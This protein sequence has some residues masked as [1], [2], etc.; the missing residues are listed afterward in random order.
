MAVNVLF[1]LRKNNVPVESELIQFSNPLDI[2][3][4]TREQT[5]YEFWTLVPNFIW[6]DLPT[7]LV[8]DI[9]DNHSAFKGMDWML[10]R[11]TTS[12]Y[13]YHLLGV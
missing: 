10:A 3:K 2:V 1:E 12:D 4:H 5:Y 13:T 8:M 11:G 7:T 9:E 6:S